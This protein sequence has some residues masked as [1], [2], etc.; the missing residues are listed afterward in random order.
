MNPTAITALP[1]IPPRPEDSHKGTFGKVLVVAGSRGMTGAAILCGT[2]ALR[3]GAG[4]VQ[5][6]TPADVQAVV[7]A[8]NP[9]YTTACLPIDVQG[10]LN[11]D[12]VSVILELARGANVLAVGPGLGQAKKMGEIM[13]Y[14]LLQATLPIVLDADGIN[15]LAKLPADVLRRR[16]V[17]IVLTPHP[18]E[19]GRLTRK[20]SKEVQE[21]RE[22]LAV[23]FAAEHNVVLVLKG[24]GTL[25]TDGKRLYRNNTGNPGMAKGGSGDLLTGMIAALIAQGLSPF[26]AAQLGVWAHGLA[27]DLAA[28]IHG[29]ISLLATDILDQLAK[30]FLQVCARD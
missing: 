15:A 11:E 18:G 12:A 3:S 19:F 27:G 2:A 6:A 10:H 21:N 24:H 22:A 16:E 9:C 30:A 1:K 8:G 20:S 5:V 25:V 29:E 28:K 7:A 13:E 4:L 26:D 14:L 23:P 17:P